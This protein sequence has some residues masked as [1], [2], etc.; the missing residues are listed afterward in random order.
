M[1][2]FPAT[3]AFF[4]AGLLLIGAGFAVGEDLFIAFEEETFSAHL[5]ERPLKAVTEKIESET[6]IWFEAGEALLQER[7]SVVFEELPLEDGLDRILSKMNYSLVFD[8][9]EAIIG[10]FLF[11]RVDTREKQSITRA[12][13]R[14]RI[15]VVR[16]PTPR[17]RTIPRR[18]PQPFR[19]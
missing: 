13:S 5:E 17:S 11:R 1:T 18:Q 10:V 9:D 8:E 4:F 15:P 6:G 16:R 19:N 14:G 3:I 12:R 7:V 2:L